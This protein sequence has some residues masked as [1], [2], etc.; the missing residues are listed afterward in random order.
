[1]FTLIETFLL[2]PSSVDN[3]MVAVPIALP[4]DWI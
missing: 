2:V 3:V 1:M 4:V